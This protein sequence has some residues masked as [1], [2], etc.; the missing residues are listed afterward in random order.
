MTLAKVLPEARR[1]IAETIKNLGEI[2]E[3]I[4]E[5]SVYE[6]ACARI[7]KAVGI[8]SSHQYDLIDQRNVLHL[9]KTAAAAQRSRRNN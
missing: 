7:F 6:I 5:Q 2:P 8:I 1:D 9:R 3:E 4:I